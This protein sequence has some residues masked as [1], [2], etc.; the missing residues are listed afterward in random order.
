MTPKATAKKAAVKKQ[1]APAAAAPKKKP[2]APAA[3]APKTRREQLAATPSV[4]KVDRVALERASETEGVKQLLTWDDRFYE[5]PHATLKGEVDYYISVTSFLG[6]T[7]PASGALEDFKMKQAEEIG[8]EQAQY[9]LFLAGQH[10]TS[11]HD[12]I[13][14]HNMGEVLEWKRLVLD[15][16]TGENIY[17]NKYDDFEWKRIA[18]YMQ[19]EE[20]YMPEFFFLE[21]KLYSHKYRV[22]GTSDGGCKLAML[23]G[24]KYIVDWKISK[25]TYEDYLMQAAFYFQMWFEMTGELLDGCAVLALGADRNKA[26]WKCKVIERDETKMF[27]NQAINRLAV[28]RDMKGDD[29]APKRDL[30]PIS[31]PGRPAAIK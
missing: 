13:Y 3:A 28:Y 4:A 12:A 5:V 14:R 19:W 17:I 21:K 9:Q 23:D 16:L 7:K 10:G 22:A 31:F 15:P 24:K 20:Q 1:P 6:A 11:V 18:R 30:L 2:A 27:L 29:F 8:R 25:D 26:G